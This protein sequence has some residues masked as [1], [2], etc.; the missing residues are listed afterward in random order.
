MSASNDFLPSLAIPTE[1]AARIFLLTL[2][3]APVS[4][5]LQN[6]P[7]LLTR[8]SRGW[9]TIALGTSELWESLAID[10]K[11]LGLAVSRPDFLDGIRRWL[12]SASSRPLSVTLSAGGPAIPD[13]IL[14]LLRV[15]TASSGLR[16]LDSDLPLGHTIK[17][18][19]HGSDVLN[20]LEIYLSDMASFFGGPDPAHI[21]TLTATIVGSPH[22]TRLHL[23]DL[24][25]GLLPLVFESKSDAL[26]ELTDLLYFPDPGENLQ[27][28][29]ALPHLRKLCLAKAQVLA[30]VHLPIS[31]LWPPAPQ[32]QELQLK[33]EHPSILRRLTLPSLKT[34]HIDLS[35]QGPNQGA[36]D[37]A[38]F[39][40]RSQCP[41]ES[42]EV[43][44]AWTLEG[45]LPAIVLPAV[46]MIRHL[47]IIEGANGLGHLLQLVLLTR[48]LNGAFLVPQLRSL[49]IVDDLGQ[50]GD[51]FSGYG[52]LQT[53]FRARNAGLEIVKFLDPEFDEDEDFD[54]DVREWMD[55]E[56]ELLR[57]IVDEWDTRVIVKLGEEEHV[58]E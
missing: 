41:L 53:A 38:D 58:V 24:L 54:D 26:Q 31:P 52:T 39:I 19:D 7:L 27:T 28:I 30:T 40:A 51:R 45:I 49:T 50:W 8:V 2:P 57:Q 20:D 29:F 17:L 6:A 12:L 25:T 3:E 46:P 9:R 55:L 34:M 11:I 47:E 23:S 16:R 5:N 56:E 48:Q 13:G 36:H 21:R 15:H 1:I 44:I 10:T 22:L 14:E 32:I 18:L 35:G 43:H 4:P 37:F 42:L 33:G